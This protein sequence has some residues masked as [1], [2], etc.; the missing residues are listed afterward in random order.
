MSNAKK[1]APAVEQEQATGIQQTEAI[2]EA[3]KILSDARAE[4][5]QI[6]ASAQAQKDSAP[7]DD[8]EEMVYIRLFKDNDKYKDDV[9]VAVNGERVQIRRGEKVQIKRKFADVLEQ[10]LAQDTSTANLIERE[11]TE[12]EA[13]A[14]A[15]QI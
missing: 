2:A 13:K 9:F 15:L 8:G 5:E 10:S 11:S 12:Y 14:A 6:V 4:A 3:E 1:E 7:A